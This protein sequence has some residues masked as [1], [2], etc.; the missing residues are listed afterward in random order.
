M[1]L[2]AQSHKLQVEWSHTLVNYFSFLLSIFLQ[3]QGLLYRINQVLIHF[4][5]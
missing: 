5:A 4:I 3:V 2:A 1:L